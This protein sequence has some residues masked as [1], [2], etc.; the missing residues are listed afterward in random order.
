MTCISA[1]LTFLTKINMGPKGKELTIATKNSIGQMIGNGM[2]AAEVCKILELNKSTV[3]KFL[4]RYR[5]GENVENTKRTGR[6]KSLTAL[7]KNVLSRIVKNERRKS[8]DDIIAKFNESTPVKVSR[9][10]VQREL[11]S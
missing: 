1:S 6:P 10:T 2:K 9:R 5:N 8:L 3:S 4:K 7:G 11:H